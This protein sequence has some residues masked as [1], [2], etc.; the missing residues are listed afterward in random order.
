MVVPTFP[1]YYRSPMNQNV[2]NPSWLAQGDFY[3][4]RIDILFLNLF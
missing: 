2:A 3:E 1:Q 4:P